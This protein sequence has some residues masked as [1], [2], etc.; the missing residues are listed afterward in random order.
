MKVSDAIAAFLA[1]HVRHV[2]TISG[3]A[4]LRVLNT[5]YKIR[6]WQCQLTESLAVRD[7][8]FTQ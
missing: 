4:D 7:T 6:S 2:F 8:L 1:Q 3:G 5:L